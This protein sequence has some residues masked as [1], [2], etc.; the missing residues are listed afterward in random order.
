MTVANDPPLW[1][2][3]DVGLSV[4]VAGG[5]CGVTVSCACELTPF[6]LA[7][8]VAVVFAVTELVSIRNEAPGCPAGTLTVGGGV[9]AAELLDSVTS[10]PASG[11]VPFI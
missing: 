8:I 1:P 7:V 3:V 5:C 4:S 11:A 6:Q 10:A 2:T 9:A